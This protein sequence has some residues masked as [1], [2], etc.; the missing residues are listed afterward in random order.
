MEKVNVSH[1]VIVRLR[2]FLE[3]EARSCSMEPSIITPEYVFRMWVGSVSLE[4]IEVALD[5]IRS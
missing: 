5:I 2:Q 4:E 1:E 3:D